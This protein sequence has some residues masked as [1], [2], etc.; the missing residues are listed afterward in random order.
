MKNVVSKK[1]LDLK[2]GK[3]Q[4][5]NYKPNVYETFLMKIY[6]YSNIVPINVKRKFV[7]YFNIIFFKER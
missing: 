2:L 6:L 3:N 4:P 1:M 5:I 7:Y